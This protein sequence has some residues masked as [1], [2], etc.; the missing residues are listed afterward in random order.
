MTINESANN[1]TSSYPLV[2]SRPPTVGRVRFMNASTNGANTRDARGRKARFSFAPE[3]RACAFAGTYS[4]DVDHGELVGNSIDLLNP[5]ACF[6]LTEKERRPSLFI[7]LN[8]ASL[9]TARR[10]YVRNVR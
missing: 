10:V 3:L 8:G 2:S 5:L 9:P 6:G 7:Q 1:V 4:N